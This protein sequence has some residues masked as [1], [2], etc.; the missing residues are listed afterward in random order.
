MVTLNFREF[1]GNH[2]LN[3][4]PLNF[5]ITFLCPK[6]LQVSIVRSSK[7]VTRTKIGFQK[8]LSHIQVIA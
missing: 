5:K 4:Q 1:F 6:V 7:S 8:S 2:K 3:E